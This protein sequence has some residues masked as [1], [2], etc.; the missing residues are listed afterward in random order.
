[1]RVYTITAILCCLF[2]IY[3][4]FTGRSLFGSG[5]RSIFFR[6]HSQYHK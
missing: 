1:M 4:N 2:L 3:M 5:G 6:G